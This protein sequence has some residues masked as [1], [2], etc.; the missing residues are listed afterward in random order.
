[1]GGKRVLKSDERVEAYGTVD[2]LNS[3]IGMV[4]SELTADKKFV[5][6]REELLRIQN[7]LLDIGSS[8]A[9]PE[10]LPV[11]HLEKRPR[12]F[13]KLID[14][15]SSELP[16]LTNFILP[17]GGKVG[18]QLHFARTV[19]RRAE[20]R[21]VVVM[22]MTDIDQAIV[23]YLNRLSDLLFTMSRFVNRQEKQQETIWK[24]A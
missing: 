17:S 22:Q 23:I 20:R 3:V 12:E 9:T 4:L 8:L 15:M 11:V 13:E 10:G 18:S 24:K 14:L 16:K 5:T 1:M 6:L 19:C 2:E 7:D 21:V